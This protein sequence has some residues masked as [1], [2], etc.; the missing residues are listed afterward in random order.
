MHSRVD[1]MSA[2]GLVNPYG[3]MRKRTP[4]ADEVSVEVSD[5]RYEKNHTKTRRNVDILRLNASTGKK[6]IF[7]AF[8]EATV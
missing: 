8:K 7:A 3:S 4:I 2:N 1:T 5:V 6:R